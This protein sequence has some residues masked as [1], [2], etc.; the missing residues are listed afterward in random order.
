MQKRFNVEILGGEKEMNRLQKKIMGLL[1]SLTL[2]LSLIPAFTLPA[3]AVAGSPDTSWYTT[4]SS[5]TSFTISNADELAGLAAIVNAGTDEFSG[6]TITLAEAGTFDLSAYA[7]GTGW[8]SIGTAAHP[9]KGYFN[10]SNRTISN[11]TINTAATDSYGLFGVVQASTNRAD[12]VYNLQNINLT[13]VS[14]SCTGAGAFPPFT[15][16]G[17]LAGSITGSYGLNIDNCTV[18]GSISGALYTGGLFGYINANTPIAVSQCTISATVVSTAGYAGG[19]AGQA[20]YTTFSN[21]ANTGSVTAAGNA[22]GIV[23]YA[24]G[25]STYPCAFKNATNSGAIAADSSSG[26]AAGGIVGNASSANFTTV[27]NT[28]AVSGW[29]RVGGIV[30]RDS[31][32]PNFITDAYNTGT[33]TGQMLS[34]GIVGETQGGPGYLITITQSFNVGNVVGANTGSQNQS[35]GGI[36]GRSAYTTVSECFNYAAVSGWSRVGGIIG[37]SQDSAVNNCYNTGTFPNSIRMNAGGLVGTQ[38]TTLSILNSYSAAAFTHNLGAPYDCYEILSGIGNSG[39]IT[40]SNLFY[41]SELN[42]RSFSYDSG[43]TSVTSATCT[44]LTTTQM[45]HNSVLQSGDTTNGLMSTLDSSV[46]VKRANDTH[47]YYPELK[48]FYHSSNSVVEYWS[49][50]SV[51]TKLVPPEPV[52][53]LVFDNGGPSITSI[54]KQSFTLEASINDAGTIYYLVVPHD[55][56]APTVEQIING[57]YSDIVALGNTATPDS[58]YSAIFNV[59]Q[60]VTTD[61]QYDVY[62]VAKDTAGN[63]QTERVML[64]VMI[65]G[66]NGGGTDPGPTSYTVSYDPNG[67]NGTAPAPATVVAGSSLTTLPGGTGLTK[68]G[69][70]FGGWSTTQS[71]PAISCPYT[72]SGS[73]T[74]YAVWVPQS[75]YYAITAKPA[76]LNFGTKTVGYGASA[77]QTVTVKNTGNSAV[78]LTQPTSTN[79]TNYTIDKLSTTTLEADGMATFTV[80]PKT[81]LAAGTY[82]ETLTVSGDHGTS[83][84]V[85]LSFKVA[86]VYDIKGSVTGKAG[87]TVDL[88]LWQGRTQIGNTVNLNISAPGEPA[89][90]TFENV[91]AGEYNVV[92][93]SQTYGY[94][95]TQY[96]N[97][98][99]NLTF[100]INMLEGRTE[101][102][103]DIDTGAPSA[104][105]NGLHDLFGDGEFYT[106]GETSIVDDN[107]G[108]VQ[109]K[110][111]VSTPDASDAGPLSI[112]KNYS[113]VVTNSYFDLDIQ[114][115]VY[116]DNTSITNNHP[117]NTSYLYDLGIHY[118]DVLV[119][120]PFNAKNYSNLAVVRYHDAD[121]TGSG[122]NITVET[123]VP[124]S[125]GQAGEWYEILRDTNQVR[126]HLSKFST[127]AFTSSTS[128]TVTFDAAGGSAG[129]TSRTVNSGEIIGNLPAA[130][131]SG[132]SFDGWFTAASGGTQIYATDALYGNTTLYAHWTYTGGGGS[133][134]IANTYTITFDASG[135]TA[136]EASRL[137]KSGAAIGTL[138]T[139]TRDGYT[140]GGWFTAASGGTK[141]TSTT[142]ATKNVTYYAH[143]TKKSTA[144]YNADVSAL[145]ETDAHNWYMQGD[146]LGNFN[147]TAAMT[148]A[149]MAQMFYNLLCDKNVTVSKTLPDIKADEWYAKAVNV[150]TELGIVTGRDDGLY[151]PNDK[152]TR[153]EFMTVAVRFGTFT[154]DFSKLPP[155]SFTDVSATHWAYDDIAKAVAVG[156]IQGDTG[157][158]SPDAYMTRAEVATLVNRMLNREADAAVESRTDLRQYHDMGD[159][160]KWYWLDV[161]EASNS[162][163]YTRESGVESWD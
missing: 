63:R 22:G 99:K 156:W 97:V 33:I 58:P 93:Y 122:T 48:A 79:Y 3:M 31:G 109:F 64:Q 38:M 81:G 91:P 112:V 85:S 69:Y 88:S 107:G 10:G 76:T 1:L 121:G 145:L 11:L 57:S 4:N 59:S 24:V 40:A 6:D 151:H 82:N 153:A 15:C 101:S 54:A 83:A 148:R 144:S 100:S 45:V 56:T 127:Y 80:V 159:K 129:E 104:V 16:V 27:H 123:L 136:S 89:T 23:G 9:F 77:S 117:N 67:G 65:P 41:D 110:L 147:P 25:S 60:G 26:A 141:V 61:T 55:A 30:G 138:P 49:K 47:C 50:Q 130:T 92:A 152:M 52:T 124:G 108:K 34:G 143:W 5:A 118:I 98:P 114:K 42:S 142:T 66:D 161:T 36:V 78:T 32:G 90:H 13:N 102:L 135:G 43:L 68:S 71:G 37:L 125:T 51:T 29:T 94:K 150:M 8:T 132:Y 95:V 155:L 158:L 160:T 119:D 74:L 70:T 44:T 115:N 96:L 162:H 39:G 140:F 19:I 134:T 12:G 137:V 120:L 103:L 73:I 133:N 86:S 105:E 28:G 21:V 154:G 7:A 62:V 20:S 113:N 111:L 116:N 53:P 84:A 157:K 2:L 131:R 72:P 128:Y 14:V 149:E 18:A 87:D 106:P 17:G 126:L 35:F 163:D 75:S 46:W 139:A 146:D